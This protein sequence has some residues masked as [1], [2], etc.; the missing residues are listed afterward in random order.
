MDSLTFGSPAIVRD[1]VTTSFFM[2]G[3]SVPL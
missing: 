2:L 3:R 1:S